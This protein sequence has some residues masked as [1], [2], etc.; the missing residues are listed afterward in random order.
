MTNC[1]WFRSKLEAYFCD[2][3]GDEELRACQ[4]H[5]STCA[6]CRR[7]VESL[8]GLD[9]EVRQVFERRLRIAQQVARADT[10]PRVL[11]VALA[12]AG[13]V[14]AAT[15]LGLGLTF[16]QQSSNPAA[17]PQPPS[18]VQ[19]P[20]EVVKDRSTE[21]QKI[22]R[23]K[24]DDGPPAPTASQQSL[25]SPTPDG[26]DFAVTDAAGYTATLET[27]RGR[28]LL[29]GVVSSDQKAAV[30]NLQKIYDAFGSNKGIGILGVLHHRDDE[31]AGAT[32]PRVFNH[33]SK[34]LGVQEGQFLLLDETGKPRLEGSLLDSA[35]I[36][37]IK[38]QLAQLGLH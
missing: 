5:L 19:Q 6:D 28:V 34:L 22:Y 29:F 15:V 3:L 17:S 16:L 10:R 27:Y 8:K 12:G 33:G 26:P 21:S 32:F 36:A 25:D 11:K 31:L 35:S 24:P 9:T 7:Q 13:L 23:A 4:T 1:D 38:T 14:V 18:V 37:R 30:E 20:P 2:S